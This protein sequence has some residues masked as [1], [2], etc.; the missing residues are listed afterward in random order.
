MWIVLTL[1]KNSVLQKLYLRHN[2]FESVAAAWFRD[3]L[4]INESLRVLDLSWNHLRLRG[5]RSISEG[6]QVSHGTEHRESYSET[7]L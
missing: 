5:A 4:A 6:V 2:H 7:C 1:Q 3:G